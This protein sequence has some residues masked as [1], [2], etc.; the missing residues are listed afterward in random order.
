MCQAICQNSGPRAPGTGEQ[1]S[2]KEDRSSL[3]LLAQQE[4]TDYMGLRGWGEASFREG[5]LLSKVKV[6]W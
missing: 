5:H 2:S 1:T 4:R 3:C 6:A